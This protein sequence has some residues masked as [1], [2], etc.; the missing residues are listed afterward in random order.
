M[1]PT[2]FEAEHGRKPDSVRFAGPRY[3][4]DSPCVA[5]ENAPMN[6][7]HRSYQNRREYLRNYQR[8]WLLRR[9]RSFFEGKS[10]VKCGS[11]AHL[12]LDHIDPS[13][14]DPKLTVGTGLWGW[15][16][17]R[18]DIE[19]AKCQVLC[20]RCH[21]AKSGIERRFVGPTGTKWCAKHKGFLPVDRFH[22]NTSTLTGLAN[23]CRD[24][25]KERRL[26]MARMRMESGLPGKQVRP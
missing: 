1:V 4:L 13:T 10:C 5:A 17:A 8:L 23:D 3:P 2:P 14:K 22:S 25:S 18:R 7:D 21:A 16:Q 26:E 9:R 6:T 19:I 11:K 24:C 20:H 15:T 12:E